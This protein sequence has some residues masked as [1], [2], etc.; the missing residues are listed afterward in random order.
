MKPSLARQAGFSLVELMV[1]LTLSLFVIVA[2]SASYLSG[3]Q[4]SRKLEERI[5]LQ[6]DARL[7]LATLS[8]DLRMAG[9][10]GCAVPAMSNLERS[11]PSG[12]TLRE[13]VAIH[14]HFTPEDDTEAFDPHGPLGF[15]TVAASG[16]SWMKN[17]AVAATGPML[18]V[19]FGQGTAA[20]VDSQ[21]KVGGSGTV[22]LTRLDTLPPAERGLSGNA[23][24]LAIGSCSRLDF[25]KVGQNGV[26]RGASAGIQL[27]FPASAALTV[28][29]ANGAHRWG[30]LDVMR[31]V[32]RAY[33]AGSYQGR[34]G[35]YMYERAENGSLVGP[36]EIAANVSRIAV[37]FGTINACQGAGAAT[38]ITYSTSPADWRTVDL[39]RLLITVESPPS[40]NTP[41]TSRQ[42]GTTI[43][44]RGSNLCVNQAK[45]LGE[46]S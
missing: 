37:E 28:G 5:A 30:S 8:R 31:F 44:V 6:Q 26:V 23:R 14:Q 20:V 13:G 39:V 36:V 19:Q 27:T 11:G 10:F 25:V 46:A 45:V 18:V 40:S 15:R 34:Q 41:A 12:V 32:S 33:V 24:L 42:Y 4:A 21:P 3:R 7:A 2:V 35:L 38:K 1:A 17:A 16:S 22:S 43:A 29:Q 9:V